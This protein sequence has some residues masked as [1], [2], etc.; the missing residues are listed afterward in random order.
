MEFVGIIH[1]IG[2]LE[3]V[4]GPSSFT[5][6]PF[7]VKYNDSKNKEQLVK[8]VFYEPQLNVINNYQINDRVKINFDFKGLISQ[9]N[10]KFFEEKI[11]NSITLHED[12]NSKKSNNSAPEIGQIKPDFSRSYDEFPEELIY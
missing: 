6:R 12:T 1:S 5:K 2:E 11:A 9:K 10:G 3:N 4:N 8:F 7:Y